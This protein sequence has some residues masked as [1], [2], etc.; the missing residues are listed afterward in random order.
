MQLKKILSYRFK[1][2]KMYSVIPLWKQYGNS[3]LI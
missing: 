2:L 1:N 3:V